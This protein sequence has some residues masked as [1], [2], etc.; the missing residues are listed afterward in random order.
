MR[1]IKRELVKGLP[2]ATC[3]ICGKKAM[4]E[5]FFDNVMNEKLPILTRFQLKAVMKMAATGLKVIGEKLD[6]KDK[7][8]V[9][10]SCLTLHFTH[11]KNVPHAKALANVVK[12]KDELGFLKENFQMSKKLINYLW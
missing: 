5:D 2:L 3:N 10:K 1:T 6:T 8:E 12:T 11:A 4:G 9:I 7:K